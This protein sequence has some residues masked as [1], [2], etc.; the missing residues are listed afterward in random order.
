MGQSTPPRK[1][2]SAGGQDLSS[3][4]GLPASGGGAPVP[5]ADWVVPEL[6]AEFVWLASLHG[7]VGK[8]PVTNGEYR[9]F[10]AGHSSGGWKGCG[11]D[12]DR[13]PA[14]LVSY[15]DA[16]SYARWLTV[17]EQRAGRVPAPLCYSLPQGEQWTMVAEGTDARTYPWGDSWPP[18]YG[19][20]ADESARALGWSVIEGYN[21]GFAVSCPVEQSGCNE[22]R[23]CGIGGNVWEW[24]QEGEGSSRVVRGGSWL[25]QHPD[26]ICC[27]YRRFVEP[28]ESDH[29][30][31][32]RLLLAAR[33]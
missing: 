7:W 10:R 12:G 21:D 33:T 16:S 2:P 31:G 26:V 8:Y 5:G 14:V 6:G 30:I 20:Y 4:C 17:R 28:H 23:V 1:M 19:N 27:R 3:R 13:Q 32:F 29:A 24:T 9:C 11:L 22:W 18:A 25:S 15:N